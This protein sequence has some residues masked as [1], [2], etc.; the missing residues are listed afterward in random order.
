[1][2]S[3][4][5]R[6]AAQIIFFALIAFISINHTLAEAG[7]GLSFI[8]EVSLHA[9][10]PFGAVETLGSFLT[11]WGLIRQL[12]PSVMVIGSIILLL[13]LLFGPVF[14]S[15]ICPLG[16]I[17]EWIGKL[18]RKIFK[19]RYN[20]LI[21]KKVHNV[22]K[23]LRYVVLI[24][25]LVQTYRSASLIFTDADPYYAL[26][27]FWT[28]EATI[29]ALIILGVTLV[30]SLFVERPWCKYA[31]PYGGLLG[32]FSKISLF[33]IRRSESKCIDCGKCDKECPM[34]I[35]ISKKKRVND[36]LCNRCMIC[37]TEEGTCPVD[38]ACYNGIMNAKNEE[39]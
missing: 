22:L 17:Q 8:P 11:G 6:L 2:K 34:L 20:K 10:C 19:N 35:D 33:K 16:S 18:G 27:H 23:Y 21:P 3:K 38:G 25:I 26:F 30:M 14:C 5:V 24:L 9:I 36:T 7:A 39:A 12:H 32:I 13:T 1:M 31:C 15:H 29:A 37:T 28:G 4:H